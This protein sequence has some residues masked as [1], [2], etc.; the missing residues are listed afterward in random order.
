MV[1]SGE[2]KVEEDGIARPIIEVGVAL[3][4]ETPV[5]E[6]FLVDTGADRSVFT[7]RLLAKLPQDRTAAGTTLIGLGGQSDSFTLEATIQLETVAGAKVTI[8]GQFAAIRQGSEL[9]I[10]ILG[11]DVLSNFDTIVSRRRNE[12][13]L[14]AGNHAYAVTG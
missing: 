13:L 1:I 9:D 12:V 11:R 3:G 2:W 7:S 10:S 5:N 4:N 6:P 8:R 14:L